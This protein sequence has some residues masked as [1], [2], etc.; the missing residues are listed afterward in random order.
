MVPITTSE[1]AGVSAQAYGEVQ[2]ENDHFRVTKWTIEPGGAIPMHRHEYE[3][4][5]VPLVTNAMHVV[6]PDGD[7]FVAELVTGRSY[8]RPVGVEHRVENRVSETIEFVEVETLL[9]PPQRD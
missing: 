2:L 3:Y 4:V 6:G 8:S 5:V 7:E 1:G 9:V